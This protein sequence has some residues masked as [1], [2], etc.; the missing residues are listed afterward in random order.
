MTGAFFDT[1]RSS[2]GDTCE[3]HA[4]RIGEIH[5]LE[6]EIEVDRS[7]WIALRQFPQLH[8]NPV[9]VLVADQ[10]IRASADSARWCAESVELLW[11]RRNHLIA[12]DERVAAEAAYQRGIEGEVSAE[13]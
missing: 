1:L 6:F 7:S 9:N 11:E 2:S 3:L 10:P 8:T 13:E 4:L 12:D 5:E